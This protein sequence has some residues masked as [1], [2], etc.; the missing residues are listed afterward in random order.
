MTA[1]FGN[2]CRLCISTTGGA[3]AH[4]EA[5]S[6]AF[7]LGDALA[8]VGILRCGIAA[9]VDGADGALAALRVDLGNILTALG[10]YDDAER[11]LRAAAADV[12]THLR[13]ARLLHGMCLNALGMLCRYTARFDDAAGYYELAQ[14]ELRGTGDEDA[15][16]T[17]L[18][19]IAGL[20]HAREDARSGIEAGQESVRLRTARHG[21]NSVLVAGDLSNL[22]GLLFDVGRVEEAARCFSRACEI[23]ENS[24][25]PDHP[26]VAVN[27]GN[28]AAV[29]VAGDDFEEAERLYAR[30]IAI[31]TR[32]WGPDNPTTL[33]SI[34]NF[35]RL[36][37]RMGRVDEAWQHAL[38]VV[39]GLAGR[40]GEEHRL[41]RRARELVAELARISE[42]RL[43]T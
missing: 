36:L 12:D 22:G 37:A 25:G 8:A 9:I 21:E 24:Y 40:V 34:H 17:I 16:A 38:D 18:H 19:N 14:T 32:V 13:A 43:R 41:L 5:A 15:L 27:L 35:A 28:L 20:A 31:K 1:N 33:L 3:V 10:Q 39:A 26:E 4:Q 29:A 2:D 11:E 6:A 23:F 42:R 7:E 30:A